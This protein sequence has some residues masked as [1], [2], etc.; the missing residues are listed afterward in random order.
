M[1]IQVMCVIMLSYLMYRQAMRQLFKS[2]IL[3]N[4]KADHVAYALFML[5]GLLLG[6]FFSLSLIPMWPDSVHSIVQIGVSFICS[7]F[8]GEWLYNRNRYLVHKMIAPQTK[9]KK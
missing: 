3:N 2:R 1:I 5:S 6:S 9:E 8:I 7:I 4:M